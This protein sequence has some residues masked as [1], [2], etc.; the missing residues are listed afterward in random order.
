VS[1]R[2]RLGIVL[3][4]VYLLQI[5]LLNELRV[6]GVAPDALL[7]LT[8]LVAQG[9]GREA[10]IVTGFTAGLLFDMALPTPLGISALSLAIVGNLVASLREN[11]LETTPVTAVLGVVGTSAVGVLLFAVTG[12]LFGQDTLEFP[13]VLRIALVVGLWNVVLLPVFRRPVAWA[14]AGEVGSRPP[15]LRT[16]L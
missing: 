3:V 15:S 6:F 8:I 9:G 2:I 11:A 13:R 4:V 5:S 16:V 7:L 12:E 10:G 14:L 1:R